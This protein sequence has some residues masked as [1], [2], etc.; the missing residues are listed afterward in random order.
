V[1][2]RLETDG[3]E[4][5]LVLLDREPSTKEEISLNDASVNEIIKSHSIFLQDVKIILGNDIDIVIKQILT[6][7]KNHKTSGK[8][9][10]DII[11]FE[12]VGN[13]LNAKM[14]LWERHTDGGFHKIHL[15]GN[16]FDVLNEEN[17]ESIIK[18]I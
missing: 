1:A 6:G 12:A 8:I 7:L 11:A 18:N 3:L 15:S 2:K 13:Q 10:G 16:H 17:L 5:R 4:T 9:K 14:Q